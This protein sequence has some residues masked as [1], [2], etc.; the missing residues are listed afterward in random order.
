MSV[1]RFIPHPFYFFVVFVVLVGAFVVLREVVDVVDFVLVR[2]PPLP[3][4]V[5][6][7]VVRVAPPVVDEL[8]VREVVVLD[9][10]VDFAVLGRD[11]VDFGVGT[12]L[13]VVVVR[14][15]V[16]LVG[17]DVPEASAL[18]SSLCTDV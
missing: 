16:V 13:V 14:F 15:V 2:V 1:S 7:V 9:A 11:V 8:G 5:V 12:R 18:P 4:R 6:V 17:V 10:T 3:V